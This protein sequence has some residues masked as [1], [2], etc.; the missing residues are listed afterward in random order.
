MEIQKEFDTVFGSPDMYR[1]LVE[2]L[3]A[4]IYVADAEG[5]LVYV[6]HAFAYILGYASK[7]ELIGLNL[8][9][10]LYAHSENRRDFLRNIEKVG[11]VR[12]YEVD[13]KRKDGSVVKLSVTSNI[14]YDEH[15]AV[16]GVEGV[17]FDIT[18][19][20]RLL[21]RLYILEKAVEQTADHVMITDKQGVIQ[22]VNPAF[23]ITTGYGSDELI[24]KTPKIL[25]S[26]KQG[27][28]YY[29]KLWETILSGETFFAQT[30]NKKKNGEFYVADQVI[31]PITNEAR[32][33]THFVSI[34]KDVTENVRLEESLKNEKR[35][36]EEIIGF[37]EKI[38]AIRKSE[39]LMDFV[40][41][42]TMNILEAQKCS[43]MFV[44]EEREELYLKAAA[45]FED[46]PEL[47]RIKIKDSRAA[48]VV[49]D[50][51]PVLVKGVSSDTMQD[52]YAA[53]S[54]MMVPIRR[55]GKTIGVI[56]VADKRSHLDGSGSFNEIDLKILCDIAREVAVA[57]ENVRFYKELQFL[58]TT[59]PITNIH[60]YR[61]FSAS[62]DYEIKRLKR[63][64]G[65]LS[66]L[67]I[68]I[69]D[70]KSYNDQFG[71]PAGDSLLKEIGRIIQSNLREVDILCRYA[72]DEF[73]IVLPETKKD[74]SMILAERIRKA[75]EEAK[76]KKAVT[77][78]VGAAQH[79]PL[80]TG[81]ELTVKAD[82]ALY[83][84]KKEGKNKICGF[85][86]P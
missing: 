66:L 9:D 2:N 52:V 53:Y 14:I 86:S 31:S 23:E 40:V 3:H 45:G 6:N 48:K 21:S 30:T 71:H 67:M 34:W 19:R 42:K 73:V 50:G 70:F 37:D 62:L 38:C 79:K 7:D 22:Y 49:E 76:F 54:F 85:G 58:T 69:D 15:N 64:S 74:G 8:A 82:R 44:D 33:I 32:E 84:A 11:F 35:K 16:V 63:F 72:G 24:G 65:E 59:D 57:L 78:S 36:L 27:L 13:N 60:N 29:Q 43:I 80:M 4:G 81:H 75:V 20:K 46:K 41:S 10:Q 28:D 17:I 68:D 26:G 56:N 5:R 18:E 61:H 39:R 47:E 12:D 77:V 25:Q 55:D 1:R 51:H 83:R